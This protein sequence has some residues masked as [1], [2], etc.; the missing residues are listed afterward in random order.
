MVPDVAFD[1]VQTAPQVFCTQTH[2]EEPSEEY[3][4]SSLSPLL[5]PHVRVATG[6]GDLYLPA[7]QPVQTVEDVDTEYLPASQLVQMAEDVDAAY[8]LA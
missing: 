6:G 4:F 7:A 3:L 5:P 8:L 1:G 2:E